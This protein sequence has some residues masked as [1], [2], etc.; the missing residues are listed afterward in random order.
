MLTSV[1]EVD[2]VVGLPCCLFYSR[3][4]QLLWRIWLR[5]YDIAEEVG[6]NPNECGF[7]FRWFQQ[8]GVLDNDELQDALELAINVCSQMRIPETGW[9]A[10]ADF[11]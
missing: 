4:F 7:Y 6:L 5:C 1:R 2:R 8:G 11:F 9:A 3:V 10:L